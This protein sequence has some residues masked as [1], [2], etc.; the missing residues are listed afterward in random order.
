[1]K[2]MKSWLD[3]IFRKNIVPF[4][5]HEHAIMTPG[6]FPWNS[7]RVYNPAAIV[8]DGKVGLIF[9]AQGIERK[10]IDGKIN[11]ISVL[12]LAWSNDGFEFVLESEPIM[13][14]ARDW[15]IGGVED[16]RIIKVEE[17]YIM[18]YTAFDGEKARLA[19]AVSE[20][21]SL[22]NWKER[23]LVFP[24]AEKWTKSGAIL[25]R[26]INGKYH[27]YFLAHDF[28]PKSGESHIWHASSKDA[29]NWEMTDEPV[30]KCRKGFFDDHELEPGPPPI[31]L[32]Q[33]ILL[34]YNA[35]KVSQNANKRTFGIGWALFDKNN[36]QKLIARSDEPFLR[37][38]NTIAQKGYVPEVPFKNELENEGRI[39]GTIFSNGMVNFKN[40]WLLYYGMGDSQIGVAV[41]EFEKIWQSKY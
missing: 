7:G 36:P 3:F 39:V 41:S 17:K 8:V 18:T 23:K 38:E 19:L 35:T 27:M 37:G 26:K 14:P 40:R 10:K 9:R 15:E 1:M 11:W 30:L 28:Y 13:S 5:H 33:G 6:Q 16:P 12:G 32:P 29:L 20:S 31:F 34:I 25:S 21:K 4:R 2:I 22:L 24:N